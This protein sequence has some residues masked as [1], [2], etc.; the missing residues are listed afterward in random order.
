[1]HD[2]YI[3]ILSEDI[4]SNTSNQACITLVSCNS[5]LITTP[6]KLQA[7]EYVCS[8]IDDF[9]RMERHR[10]GV[11]QN[12]IMT[13]LKGYDKNIVVIQHDNIHE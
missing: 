1:M 8:N 13:E 5:M 9:I 4:I 12:M 11:V 10:E 2:I 7:D 3:Y 6:V